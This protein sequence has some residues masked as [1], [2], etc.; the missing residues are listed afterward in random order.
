MLALESD[1]KILSLLFSKKS[2][3]VSKLSEIFNVSPET[4]MNDLKKFEKEGIIIKAYGGAVLKEGFEKKFNH[5]EEEVKDQFLTEAE[6][7]A[8]AIV[9]EI[10]EGSVIVLDNSEVSLEIA[11]KIKEKGIGITVITNYVKV[12]NELMDE[13]NVELICV[14]GKLDRKTGSYIGMLA[15]EFVKGLR[16]DKAII[17]CTGFSL[18]K[19]VTEDDEIVASTK[20]TLAKVASEV[21]L[22]VMETNFKKNGTIKCIDID[23]ISFVFSTV[24]LPKEIEKYLWYKDIKIKYC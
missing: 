13:K 22:A 12:V 17:S 7:L 19:G 2:V 4:V 8:S 21:V 5:F 20:K 24:T 10:E 6:R 3:K 14:G 9:R 18:E 16:A 23:S 1:N 15:Q 11:K